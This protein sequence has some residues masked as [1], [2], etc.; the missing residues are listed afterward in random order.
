M[1]EVLE[2]LP[3]LTAARPA[4]D[5]RCLRWEQRGEWRPPF[6]GSLV[7]AGCSLLQ[8]LRNDF[9]RGCAT[10]KAPAEPSVTTNVRARFSKRPTPAA[11][12]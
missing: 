6:A 5:R 12:P 3:F 10:L 11:A 9:Q 1:R 2:R 4:Q 7:G 8:R